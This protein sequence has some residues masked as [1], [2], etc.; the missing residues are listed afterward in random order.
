M[1]N[2]LKEYYSRL[3]NKLSISE[4][5]GR[6]HFNVKEKL[7][8]YGKEQRDYT[9]NLMRNLSGWAIK[10]NKPVHLNLKD[11]SDITASALVLLF[12]EVTRIKIHFENDM[13]VTVALPSD[14]YLLDILNQIGWTKAINLDYRNLISLFENDDT[15]QTLSD[16]N[17]AMISIACRLKNCGVVLNSPEAKVFSKG[18]NEAMLNVIHHAYNNEEKPLEGIGRRWWQACYVTESGSMVFII[19]DFGQGILSSLPKDNLSERY[20][21][22]LARAM[23]IGVTSTDDKD[24]GKGSGDIVQAAE[25]RKDS[26]LFVASNNGIYGRIADSKIEKDES[27]IPMLGTVVEWEISYE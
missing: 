19:C 21:D 12:G 15:F 22:H 11:C 16:P 3:D 14:A 23:A 17:K 24:R 9:L 2:R 20:E 8:I 7:C 5:K 10:E 1:N 18:V 27:I 26:T 13:M 25:I 4:H 6:I